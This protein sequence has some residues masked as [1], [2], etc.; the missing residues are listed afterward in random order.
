MRGAC[1]EHRSQLV[2]NVCCRRHRRSRHRST[3]RLG[4]GPRPLADARVIVYEAAR[5]V[6]TDSARAFRIR[7]LPSRR[8]VVR[9]VSLGFRSWSDTLDLQPGNGLRGTIQLGADA[10]FP[11]CPKTGVCMQEQAGARTE[12]VT[13][14]AVPTSMNYRMRVPL[15][16]SVAA[17]LTV[18]CGGPTDPG[19]NTHVRFV[20]DAPF[21][22]NAY[23]VNFFIDDGQVGRD[24]MWFGVGADTSPVGTVGSQ[25][26][27][28]YRSYRVQ[29]GIH[30]VRAAIV[31][32]IPPYPPFTL[33]FATASPRSQALGE[34]MS[35]TC[36]T[37][38]RR[39]SKR[40][41]GSSNE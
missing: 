41:A 4:F 6:P 18:A 2:T 31:D 8:Y 29:A 26:F 13:C 9:V 11:C 40:R 22:G 27:K 15:L 34:H 25:R 16:A 19:I 24:T 28:S 37:S 5:R 1:T 36:R 12:I 30:E 3:W 39:N 20:I 17:K 21:C 38:I 10:A 33:L 7:A 32:T 14:R 23:P 35:S